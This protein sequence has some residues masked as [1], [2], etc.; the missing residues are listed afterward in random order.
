MDDTLVDQ[1]LKAL[2]G[3]GGRMRCSELQELLEGLGFYFKKKK[4]ANHKVYFHDHLPNFPSASFNCEHGK[5]P[6]VKPSYVQR[7]KREIT[8]HKEDLLRYLAKKE[9]S[10]D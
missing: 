6:P 3:A 4:T 10:N 9:K 1:A 2:E 7:A 5:D 8:L